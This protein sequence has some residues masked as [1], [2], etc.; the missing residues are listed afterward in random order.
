MRVHQGPA[1]SWQKKALN[2]T[3]NTPSGERRRRPISH[4]THP[5]AAVAMLDKARYKKKSGPLLVCAPS[6]TYRPTADTSPC[7]L[8]S[9]PKAPFYTIPFI[10][11]K[12]V[13]K[14]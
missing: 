4:P 13:K 5:K 7:G 14:V 3:L 1:G 6:S 12:Q 8:L 11:E 2:Q 9:K 10:I